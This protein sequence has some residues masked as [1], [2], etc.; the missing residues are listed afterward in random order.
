LDNR[1]VCV[2]KKAYFGS[3][4]QKKKINTFTSLPLGKWEGRPVDILIMDG[5]L[6]E[7]DHY[8]DRNPKVT[9]DGHSWKDKLNL[10][11]V[12]TPIEA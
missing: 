9:P 2:P 4:E 5:Y 3:E 7:R 1:T 6:F 8:S 10:L 12:R 11:G